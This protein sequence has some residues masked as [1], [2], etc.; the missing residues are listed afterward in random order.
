MSEWNRGR[1]G[2]PGGQRALQ[3]DDDAALESAH[4]LRALHA[5]PRV[6]RML[7]RRRVQRKANNAAGKG[8]ARIAH[9]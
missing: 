3:V 5:E 8:A 9:G 4:P 6:A 7:Y 1:Q 2:G